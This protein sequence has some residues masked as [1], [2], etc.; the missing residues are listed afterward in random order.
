MQ[1]NEVI[2]NY[3]L[4]WAFPSKFWPQILKIPIS[5]FRYDKS[6][7][8]AFPGSS[9]IKIRSGIALTFLER[10]IRA[11]RKLENSH[12]VTERVAAS[13]VAAGAHTP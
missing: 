3:L 8:P 9:G 11:K 6:D 2:V 4:G 5:S 1:Q 13:N 12:L 7:G 10:K